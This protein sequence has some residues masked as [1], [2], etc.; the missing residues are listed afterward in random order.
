MAELTRAPA[1]DPESSNAAHVWGTY[2]DP[3]RANRRRA[4]GM[5]PEFEQQVRPQSAS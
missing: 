4:Q 5:P 3:F 1:G 2:P